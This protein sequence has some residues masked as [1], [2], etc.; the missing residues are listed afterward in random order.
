MRGARS[1]GCTIIFMATTMTFASDIF[2]QS[3]EV[4]QISLMAQRM[5]EQENWEQATILLT[6]ALS[7]D[8]GE[9][10][11]EDRGLLTFSLGYLFYKK[12]ERFFESREEDLE[13]TMNFYRQ[14]LE[15]LPKNIQIMKNLILALKKAE[16]WNEATQFLHKAAEI[17]KDNRI[18]YFMEIGDIYREK[19]EYK[20]ALKYF[21][22]CVDIEPKNLGTHWKLLSTYR[23]LGKDKIKDLYDYCIK[24]KY[25]NLNELAKNGFEM[26]MDLSCDE[27]ERKAEEALIHWA[28]I[29]ASQGWIGIESLQV[30]PKKWMAPAVKELNVLVGDSSIE[31]FQLKWWTR[32]LP[33]RH[34]AA[35]VLRSIGTRYLTGMGPEQANKN[36]VFAARAYEKALEIA[37][38]LQEYQYSRLRPILPMAIAVELASLYHRHRMTDPDGTKFRKLE[39]EL[40]NDKSYHYAERDLE[41]ILRSHTILGLIY[42]ERGVWQSNWEPANGIFQLQHAVDTSRKLYE[43]DPKKYHP[44]PHLKKLLADGYK[45]AN[46]DRD[47]NKYYIEAAIGYLELDSLRDAE[48]ALVSAESVPVRNLDLFR[49]VRKVWDARKE[50]IE[51]HADNFNPDFQ[52][53]VRKQGLF[54]WVFSPEDLGLSSSFMNRQRFKALADIGSR[55]T[56]LKLGREAL[57]FHTSALRS[58][59]GEHVFSS[60]EDLVRMDKI[61]STV[62][63]SIQVENAEKSVGTGLA[64]TEDTLFSRGKIWELPSLPD[65]QAIQVGIS[66]DFILAGK[67]GNVI[68]TERHFDPEFF[69]VSLQDG[70]VII[71]QENQTVIDPEVKEKIKRNLGTIEGVRRIKIEKK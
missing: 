24:L 25:L 9:M 16:K 37:P 71:Y 50:I 69:R 1:I 56:G 51:L 26:F 22:K 6:T 23:E 40:F 58:I 63:R 36:P 35:Y 2:P 7:E 20:N 14:S 67:V 15:Y 46:R 11:I 27:E 38:E 61:K 13:Q 30:L 62:L 8:S 59:E 41:S 19:N 29:G 55:A 3:N 43:S 64:L 21:Q 66:Y 65:Q 32:N 39:R 18:T 12:A 33:R 42:A 52:A 10:T 53:Y 31:I 60:M 17:D 47:A 57:R 54:A 45:M 28:E 48:G 34:V 44:L 70:E 49:N 4:K 68:S 5:V